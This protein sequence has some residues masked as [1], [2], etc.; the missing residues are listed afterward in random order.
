MSTNDGGAAFPRT[1]ETEDQQNGDISYVSHDGM[2]LRDW[3]AGQAL[4]CAKHHDN[5][6]IMAM[7]A[8]DLADAMIA[9][10]GTQ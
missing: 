2:S 4:A 3:F 10:R 1:I 5:Q 7:R 9:E 6:T 8:Y